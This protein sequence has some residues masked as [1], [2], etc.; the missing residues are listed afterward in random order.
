MT[1]IQLVLICAAEVFS[2]QGRTINQRVGCA[3]VL[4]GRAHFQRSSSWW[5]G[6]GARTSRAAKAKGVSGVGVSWTDCSIFRCSAYQEW[7]GSRFSPLAHSCAVSLSSPASFIPPMYALRA[8]SFWEAPA[9]K[10]APSTPHTIPTF[11]PAGCASLPVPERRS[12]TPPR[13]ARTEER[14]R[15]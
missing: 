10:R 15:G 4:S 14:K 2:H 13:S 8:C 9:F 1:K 6:L 7:I 5:Y 12:P 3:V 11:Q